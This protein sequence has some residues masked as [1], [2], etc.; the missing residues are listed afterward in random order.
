GVRAPSI[1]VA[2]LGAVV[3]LILLALRSDFTQGP[4]IAR[5]AQADAGEKTNNWEFR[6]SGCIL[7]SFAFFTVL[8]VSAVGIQNY[9]IAALHDLFGTPPCSA[10]AAVTSSLRRS[11]MGVAVGGVLVGRIGNHGWFAALGICVSG[12]AILVI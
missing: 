6:M 7:R 2:I 8:A 11:A 9:S 5:R 3:T 10:N 12:A 1:V 4:H